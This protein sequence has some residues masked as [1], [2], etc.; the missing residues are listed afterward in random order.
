MKRHG[1]I[2]CLAG[3]APVVA[4]VLI[5]VVLSAAERR[6]RRVEPGEFNPEHK[7]VELFGAMEAGQLEVKF[8]PKSS[9]EANLLIENK[10]SEPLNIK[11]P[12]AFAGVPVL[13][14]F[15]GGGGF[16]GQRGGGFGGGGGGQSVGGGFGGGGGGIGGGGF[17]G[18]GQF[19][20][21]AE[22]VGK[23]EV[24]CVCLEHGKPEPRPAM[25]YEIKPIEEFTKDP[26][27]A[28]LLKMFGKGQLNHAAAQAAAWHLANGM[29]FE[30]LAAKR[31]IRA[32]G[33][34]YPYFHPNAIRAAIE[35]VAAVAE[36]T[37][38]RGES[39]SDRPVETPKL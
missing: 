30:E 19:N 10:T 24:P 31:I 15:G 3:G 13:A 7:T 35:I 9:L 2:R 32:G 4:L 27:V 36:K 21:P 1:A 37:E 34:T 20:V 14:Q 29:S 11:L 6:S 17:G 38:G 23:L 8:I 22:R 5:P 26:A 18:G 25:E 33:T 39:L 16:G 12:K 28:E